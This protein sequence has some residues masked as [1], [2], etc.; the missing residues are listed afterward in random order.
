[1]HFYLW[2]ILLTIFLKKHS[3]VNHHFLSKTCIF[4][5]TIC[6][7]TDINVLI[8]PYEKFISHGMSFFYES[9]F[10]YQQESSLQVPPKLEMSSLPSFL[11]HQTAHTNTSGLLP[12]STNQL[13]DDQIMPQ[14]QLHLNVKSTLLC[15]GDTQCTRPIPLHLQL[16]LLQFLN[17]LLL[18][19]NPLLSSMSLQMS[20]NST[21]WSLDLKHGLWKP[22]ASYVGIAHYPLPWCLLTKVGKLERDLAIL[23]V[24]FVGKKFTLSWYM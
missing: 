4:F 21:I 19:N 9:L 8:W 10:P 13:P 16:L 17:H 11:S 6:L 15:S 7:T 3:M 2:L 24:V 18:H 12:W 1:M 20:P 23:F 14:N 22:K 5:I